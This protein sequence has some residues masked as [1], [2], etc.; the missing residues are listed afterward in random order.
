MV[1]YP[2]NHSAFW[3]LLLKSKS[4][5]TWCT[6]YC[7]NKQRLCLGESGERICW[8]VPVWNLKFGRVSMVTKNITI[9]RFALLIVMYTLGK[10]IREENSKWLSFCKIGIHRFA[11]WPCISLFFSKHQVIA[12]LLPGNQQV[13]SLPCSHWNIYFLAGH[14]RT[15]FRI[16]HII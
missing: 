8:K 4:V 15:I 6:N 13:N 5:F 16:R 3:R 10:N 7:Q 11:I 2:P 14:G 1:S 9:I 12:S